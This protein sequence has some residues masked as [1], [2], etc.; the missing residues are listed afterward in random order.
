M[1]IYDHIF[2][3]YTSIHV[4]LHTYVFKIDVESY[5]PA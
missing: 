4:Y 5:G 3:L 1:Y 2:Y